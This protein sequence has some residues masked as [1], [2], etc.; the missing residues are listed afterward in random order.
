[1]TRNRKKC[2]CPTASRAHTLCSALDAKVLH[3]VHHSHVVVGF[4]SVIMRVYAVG[5]V[6]A[7]CHNPLRIVY[8]ARYAQRLK[9][10]VLLRDV[11]H[12]VFCNLVIVVDIYSQHVERI[13]V[14]E[15]DKHRVVTADGKVCIGSPT[16]IVVVYAQN[17]DL[18]IARLVVRDSY[19]LCLSSVATSRVVR[20][21]VGS[22]LCRR[23]RR[24]SMS[25][26]LSCCGSV[27]ATRCRCDMSLVVV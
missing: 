5:T 14:V 13:V 26:G 1:M 4:H 15:V 9:C 27:T 18:S 12:L 21:A 20:F 23:L 24:R 11:Y 8:H 22:R 16:I 2:V 10:D 6:V 17:L 3:I 7:C 25:G 19:H